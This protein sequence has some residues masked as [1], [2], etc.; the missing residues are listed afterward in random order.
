MEISAVIPIYNEKDNIYPMLEAVETALRKGF[1]NYEIIF[2]NDGSKDGS[3]EILEEVKKNNFNVKVY[4]F[5]KNNGQSAAIEAGFKKA[6]G[7]LVLMM[8]GDLQTDPEDVYE[9]LKYIPEYDMV[10]G[11]RAT[12]EDGFKRKLASKIGN[13]FRNFVTGDN[14]QDTGCPLKLFKK[15]VA[16]SY[17]MFNGMH[18]FLPTLA[19]YMGYK[20]KEV[21]VRHYDRLHGQSK[22][23][24]FGRGFKAFKDVF[25]VR[26]MKNRMLNWEIEGELNV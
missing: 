7:D 13:G 23:K 17:K 9:L 26:W 16:K 25:A 4:H 24:V 15:E 1:K 19:R 8:D 10:N 12:R 3:Y 18:R 14:I 5:T 11:K 22:Y 6:K 21:P 2:V 20:V